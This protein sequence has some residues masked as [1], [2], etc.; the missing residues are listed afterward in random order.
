[1]LC[2]CAAIAKHS[3][4]Y[5][6]AVT[7]CCLLLHAGYWCECFATASGIPHRYI[8][9]RPTSAVH[10]YMM[11]YIYM[12]LWLHPLHPSC[13]CMCHLH[14]WYVPH[15]SHSLLYILGILLSVSK[16]YCCACMHLLHRPTLIHVIHAYHPPTIILTCWKGGGRR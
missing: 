3:R 14:A 8:H 13:V 1:M 9:R 15:F 5:S 10:S 11:P 4:N 16:Y 12:V 7:C 6:L 2:K